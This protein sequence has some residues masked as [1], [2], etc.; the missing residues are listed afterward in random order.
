VHLI[1]KFTVTDSGSRLTSLG[2][3]P[4][5]PVVDVCSDVVPELELAAEVVWAPLSLVDPVLPPV[6]AAL[7]PDVVWAP[8]ALVVPLFVPVVSEFD[9]VLLGPPDEVVAVL[10]APVFA[11]LESPVVRVV[12][13]DVLPVHTV[14][15]GLPLQSRSVVCALLGTVLSSVKSWVCDM[16]CVCA[17]VWS[18]SA[19]ECV[20]DW[21]CE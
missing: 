17:M 7:C 12:L 16:P 4:Q 15:S 10:A 20:C 18:W 5:D 13:S 21:V 8:S 2:V 11:L 14:Q 3:P 6:F 9:P 19:I 1:M